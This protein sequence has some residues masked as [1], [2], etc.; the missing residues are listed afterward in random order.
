MQG[1]DDIIA[2]ET[3]LISMNGQNNSMHW[4]D[5]GCLDILWHIKIYYQCSMLKV[6]KPRMPLK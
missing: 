3:Y 4:N 1:I 6:P 2:L 5:M